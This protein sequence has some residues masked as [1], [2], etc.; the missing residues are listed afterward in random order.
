MIVEMQTMKRMVWRVA[1][2]SCGDEKALGGF[3][4]LLP[5]GTFEVYRQTKILPLSLSL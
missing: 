1:A 2:C 4:L 5:D 3:L